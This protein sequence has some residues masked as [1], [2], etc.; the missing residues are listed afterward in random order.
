MFQEGK[1]GQL[2]GPARWGLT[3]PEEGDSEGAEKRVF[4]SSP[5]RFYLRG[6]QLE[7]AFY[8]LRLEG[9]SKKRRTERE[10]EIYGTYGWIQGFQQMTRSLLFPALVG[11][12]ACILKQACQEH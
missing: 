5:K 11:S 2:R 10:G 8:F 12:G 1:N 9:T 7:A 3:R 4:L 6:R